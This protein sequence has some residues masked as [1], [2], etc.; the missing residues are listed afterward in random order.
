MDLVFDQHLVDQGP[1]VLGLQDCCQKCYTTL[2][3]VSSFHTTEGNCFLA[4][5][6]SPAASPPN[7]VCPYGVAKAFFD[8][9]D[10]SGDLTSF[11]PCAVYA[12]PNN[13]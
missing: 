2:G 10:G 13:P 4:I 5:E 3:C 12:G 1:Y 8:P 7:N 9:P 6:G 11:G